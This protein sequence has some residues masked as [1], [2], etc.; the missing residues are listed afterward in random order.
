MSQSADNYKVSGLAI[1]VGLATV[2]LMVFTGLI[3]AFSGGWEMLFGGVER[4]TET[5]VDLSSRTWGAIHFAMGVALMAAGWALFSGKTWGR[6]VAIALSIIVLAAGIV[7]LPD[8]P[9]WGVFLIL[10]NAAVLWALIMHSE[11]IKE[12][13]A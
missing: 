3:L 1:T 10:F 9:V 2:V 5:I 6:I 8:S 12:V 11:D 13:S 4:D 7:A